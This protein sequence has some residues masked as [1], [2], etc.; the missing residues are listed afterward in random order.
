LQLD[1]RMLNAA[2]TFECD[3]CIVGAGPAGLTVALELAARGVSVVILESGGIGP[4]PAMDALNDGVVVGDEYV[5]LRATRHRA[6]GGTA[7][8]WNTAFGADIGA[9][10]VPLDPWDFTASPQCAVPAWP[11]DYATL[12]PWYRH[13]QT[14][15]GLGPFSYE[16][17]DWETLARRAWTFRQHSF[18]CTRIYQFGRAR[19]F[20]ADY[21]TALQA[22]PVAQV[23][24]HATAVRLIADTGGRIAQ[25]EVRGTPDGAA[26]KVAARFVVL[27]GGAIENARLLLASAELLASGLIAGREW[28]GRC[29]TEHPR[30]WS[31]RLIPP[32]NSDLQ[33]MGFYDAHTTATGSTVCG[34]LALAPEAAASLHIPNLSITLLPHVPPPGPI[35]R[36]LQRLGW[37]RERRGYGWSDLRSPTRFDRFQ[38]VINLEQRPHPEN[39][40]VLGHEV[41]AFGI[42]RAELHWRWSADEQTEWEQVRARIVSEIETT[43]LGRIESQRV[44]RPDPNAHHH[45]GTTRMA[46]DPAWGVVDR[47]GR[48]HGADN[49]YVAGA[50]VFSS[51]GYANPTLTV[52]ALALRLADHLARRCD[53]RTLLP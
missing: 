1:A 47:D 43:G 53:G 30:D 38:L 48:V 5:G 10:Y 15:C 22:S 34:R 13:A 4:E 33:W 27:A 31:L 49:L 52:V 35:A 46:D 41:D 25:V 21:V 44:A 42:P 16:A 24:D 40:V 9:K 20:T 32:S 14:R 6:L 36:Y 11:L 50:S 18:L 17:N 45:A 37:A 51:A 12:E 28:V 19:L 3:V 26:F 39:R 8:L 7:N 23:C 2:R 29:F